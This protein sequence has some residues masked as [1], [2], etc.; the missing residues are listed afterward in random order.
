[1]LGVT[2]IFCLAPLEHTSHHGESFSQVHQHHHPAAAA[3]EL[4]SNGSILAQPSPYKN[5]PS[6]STSIILSPAKNKKLYQGSE[7]MVTSVPSMSPLVTASSSLSHPTVTADGFISQ[8]SSV[9]NNLLHVPTSAAPPPLDVTLQP[10]LPTSQ[11]LP[12]GGI[13]SSTFKHSSI[14][15]ESQA[16]PHST[17]NS[18]QGTRNNPAGHTTPK[19]PSSALIEQHNVRVVP[20]VLSFGSMSSFSLSTASSMSQYNMPQSGTQ[21]SNNIGTTSTSSQPPVTSTPSLFKP[22]NSYNSP[23]IGNLGNTVSWLHPRKPLFTESTTSH[24]TSRSD[25][26]VLTQ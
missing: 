15:T 20:A 13:S 23:S 16:L 25:I 4:S 26:K 22:S 11:S 17:S 3:Q 2:K 21:V 18:V 1:M 9:A 10:H 8:S 14:T 7:T 24:W 6:C 5:H 12:N 19:D